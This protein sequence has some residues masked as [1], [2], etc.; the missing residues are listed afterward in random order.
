MKF[1]SQSWI[2][3]LY[4]SHTN[5]VTMNYKLIKDYLQ[6]C[7][8][9]VTIFLTC[10]R[11]NWTHE[12]SFLVD[13]KGNDFWTSLQDMSK[14][15]NI[16]NFSFDNFLLRSGHPISVIVDWDCDEVPDILQEISKRKMF[17]F[18]RYWLMFGTNADEMLNLL[19]HE[20]I[21]I[22]AE[23]AVCVPTYKK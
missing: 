15:R 7:N 2:V 20:L 18:E 5:C 21:N 11:S 13:L 4:I 12:N 16:S 3:L 17:H 8:V 23:V 19:R 14:E 22:G 6:W 10:N 1:P 9:R